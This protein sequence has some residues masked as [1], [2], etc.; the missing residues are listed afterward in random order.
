MCLTHTT[1]PIITRLLMRM[2][3]TGVHQAICCAT[4]KAETGLICF[5]LFSVML[6]GFATCS[7]GTLSLIMIEMPFFSA[8]FVGLTLTR[9]G[10]GSPTRLIPPYVLHGI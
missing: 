10:G 5:A 7:T 8:I 9:Y 6:A 1:E 4:D 2:G 3:L